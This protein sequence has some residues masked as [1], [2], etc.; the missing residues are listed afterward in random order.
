VKLLAPLHPVVTHANK[1]D[2]WTADNSFVLFYTLFHC[3]AIW[4]ITT[5]QTLKISFHIVVNLFQFWSLVWAVL[6]IDNRTKWCATIF[7]ELLH[8]A[9]RW[10]Q[11]F[12][13]IFARNI[14]YKN[15][16][17]NAIST[18]NRIIL[19]GSFQAEILWH[20]TYHHISLC[21]YECAS[22]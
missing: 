15:D 7:Y 18:K 20:K 1:S 11:L 21:L 17:W 14:W 22:K 5:T 16:V 4:K 3:V 13:I 6:W 2:W 19:Y 12:F 10:V 9:A 8:N